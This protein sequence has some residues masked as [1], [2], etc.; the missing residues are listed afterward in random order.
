M[1]ELIASVPDFVC[2][3]CGGV[4]AATEQACTLC[5]CAFVVELQIAK[6]ADAKAAYLAARAVHAFDPG[7]APSA[8]ELARLLALRPFRA[9]TQK[10]MAA[11]AALV[12]G[13]KAIP[14]TASVRVIAQAAAPAPAGLA[15]AARRPA[16]LA[17]AALVIVAAAGIRFFR[18]QAPPAPAVS[19]TALPVEH[20][21]AAPAA[22]AAAADDETLA[23]EPA[24]AD[25]EAPAAPAEA[26]SVEKVR[27]SVVTLLVGSGALGSGFVVHPGFIVTN[28]HVIADMAEG[29]TL[30]VQF[31]GE[32]GAQK[33]P[34]R[35]VRRDTKL[36]VALVQCGGACEQLP[37]LELGRAV[38]VRAGATVYA[39]GS[40]LGLDLTL[41]KG[42][43]SNA[44][45]VRNGVLFL[46][47]DAPVNPGNSGGPLFDERGRV[48]GIVTAKVLGAD[49]I[50]FILPIEYALEGPAAVLNGVVPA[51]PGSYSEAF[52][53]RLD[54]VAAGAAATAADRAPEPEIKEEIALDAAGILPNNTY[55]VRFRVLWLPTNAAPP[56]GPFYVVIEQ[57]ATGYRGT[58]QMTGIRQPQRLGEIK[59]AL[60]YAF[61]HVGQFQGVQPFAAGDKV[62]VRMRD[63]LFSNTIEL[64]GR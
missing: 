35:L 29:A 61:E 16:V 26:F 54:K 59:G 15:A 19:T 11:C 20:A 41:S 44:M 60:V 51:A 52:Q 53:A 56:N 46:Q 43:V 64:V 14:V 18:P 49:G 36:D 27:R 8:A 48:V 13:L 7:T 58:F 10:D 45:R 12:A 23:M 47:S 38:D 24:S 1:T 25:A 22:A 62:T 34:A 50:G 9:L 39:I 17:T 32:N 4:A 55:G 40:P 30:D 2:P 57:R 21:V 3:S 33:A 37:A 31:A 28:A 6:V 5:G 42:I 63:S